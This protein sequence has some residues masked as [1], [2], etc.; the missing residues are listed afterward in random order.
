MVLYNGLCRSLNKKVD[1]NV[2]DVIS[3][4]TTRGRKWRVKGNYEGHNISTFSSET[5]AKEL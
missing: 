4:N 2:E 1:F 3:M 5:V